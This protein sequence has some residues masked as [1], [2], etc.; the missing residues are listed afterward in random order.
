MEEFLANA[1][2]TAVEEAIAGLR[3]GGFRSALPCS[4]ESG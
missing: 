2:E 4:R 3:E 1:I